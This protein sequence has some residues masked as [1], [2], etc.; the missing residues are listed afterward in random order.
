MMTMCNQSF[1]KSAYKKAHIVHMA[2]AK[3]DAVFV[4]MI[5]DMMPTIP[6][7]QDILNACLT[8]ASFDLKEKENK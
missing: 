1:L 7:S 8:Q 3:E 6:V 5:H 2:L 4:S